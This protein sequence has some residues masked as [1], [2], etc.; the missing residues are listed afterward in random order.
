MRISF[1]AALAA[2]GA[3][4][5]DNDLPWK[6][7]STDLKRFKSL[8]M[9]HHLVLGRRTWESIGSKPLPGR[10]HIVVTRQPD[11]TATG[12]A[13]VGTLEEA[14][15][16]ARQA[17]D[18]ECF[19]GGGAELFTTALHRADRMYLTRVHADLEGDTFFPEFDDVSE[20]HLIDSEHF[21]ADEKN[22]YPFSFLMYDRAGAAGH[23]IPEEG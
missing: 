4:G 19:I 23:A 14:L 2:N 15:D 3:M 6:R 8:T 18:D 22:E 21:D 12:A 1:I 5:R 16:I 9:G 13:V 17:G 10:I 7:L 11:Y 20:W